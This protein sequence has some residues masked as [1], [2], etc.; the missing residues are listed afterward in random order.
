MMEDDYEVELWNPVLTF[1]HK[2]P[3]IRYIS[4]CNWAGKTDMLTVSDVIDKY[5]HLLTK[6]QHEALEA[7]YPIRAAGYTITGQ[8]NDG[9][10]YDATKSHDW[11]T[12]MPSLAY[13][14]YTSFMSGNVL[15]GSDI[16]TQILSEGEDYYDQGT[17]YLLRVTTAYWKSQRRVGHLTKITEEGDVINE[18][19][20]EDY[21]ITDNIISS[22]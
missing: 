8:Q 2:S 4:D 12:N 1:Y 16:I 5:G 17:A 10:F 15:D 13:R 11:N 22:F 18:I 7:V 9:S 3:D 20:S 14:Q 19:V 6:E 21:K